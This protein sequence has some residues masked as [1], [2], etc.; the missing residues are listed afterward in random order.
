MVIEYRSNLEAT[1]LEQTIFYY[2]NLH[3]SINA[4]SE[5]F[6]LAITGCE[7]QDV[8]YILFTNHQLLIFVLFLV[9]FPYHPL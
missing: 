2:L 1:L 5:C 8:N 6:V 4:F 9:F 7:L 3:Y